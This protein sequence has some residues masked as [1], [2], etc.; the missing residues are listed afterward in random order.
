MPL[1]FLIKSLDPL[2]FLL[3]NIVL[4]YHKQK[5]KFHGNI[6]ANIYELNCFCL[7]SLECFQND[8]WY[9]LRLWHYLTV[10]S[11][12]FTSHMQKNK[13]ISQNFAEILRVKIF[14]A[15]R[16]FC[17]LTYENCRNS[18]SRSGYVTQSASHPVSQGCFRQIL[19]I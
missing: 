4:Y 7:Y 8:Y 10:E 11:R 15:T 12:T 19:V 2:S 9:L 13:T 18:L 16:F 1:F 14:E 17:T 6:E 5:E 3:V